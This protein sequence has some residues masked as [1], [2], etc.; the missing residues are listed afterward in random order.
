MKIVDDGAWQLVELGG[1]ELRRVGQAEAGV[2]EHETVVDR[3]Q[4]AVH[5]PGPRRQRH[6]HAPQ[7]PGK[8]VHQS[9]LARNRSPGAGAAPAAAIMPANDPADHLSY[10]HDWLMQ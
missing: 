3:E 6:R 10:L 7:S 5:V 2:D 1:P 8:L 4:I 9:T